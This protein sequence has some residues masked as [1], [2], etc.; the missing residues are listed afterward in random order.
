MLRDPNSIPD[1][2]TVIRDKAMEPFFIAKSKNGG[3]TIFQEIPKGENKKSYI[4]TIAY[5]S[6][7]NRALEMVAGE[8]LSYRGKKE[9]N[10]V[11]EY[12]HEWNEV[13]GTMKH[14]TSVEI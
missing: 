2:T 9:Y 10:T 5:P 11:K 1:A 13:A 6:T 4:R 12:I 8:L 14:L 7:F 3:Y